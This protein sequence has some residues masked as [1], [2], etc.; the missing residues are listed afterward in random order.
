MLKFL[1]NSLIIVRISTKLLKF[2]QGVCFKGQMNRDSIQVSQEVSHAPSS[3]TSALG[4]EK[5]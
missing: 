2:R 5:H 4:P 3:D 1:Q